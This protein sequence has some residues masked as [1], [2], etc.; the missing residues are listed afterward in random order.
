MKG[1]STEERIESGLNS[2]TT[3][4]KYCLHNTGIDGWEGL[5]QGRFG[6][7]LGVGRSG[8]FWWSSLLSGRGRSWDGRGS[9]S[10]SILR[11]I[12]K[13]QLTS[14]GGRFWSC[15]RGCLVGSTLMP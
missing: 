2:S 11:I 6:L 14:S 4:H 15:P 5:L 10:P 7:L 3:R 8:W 12:V 13:V 1:D 9:R